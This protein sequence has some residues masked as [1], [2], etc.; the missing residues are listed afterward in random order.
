MTERVSDEY[1]L[2]S[3]NPV[4][5]A[6]SATSTAAA[7]SVASCVPSVSP[8]L[9][10]LR[11]GTASVHVRPMRKFDGA[12]LDID[13]SLTSSTER[14]DGTKVSNSLHPSLTSPATLLTSSI[15]ALAAALKE[16]GYVYIENAIPR[17]SVLKA[18]Q[19][20]V[21]HLRKRGLVKPRPEPHR[22]M[23]ANHSPT[24]QDERKQLSADTNDDDA[25][26][27][28]TDDPLL[29]STAL[30]P[31]VSPNLLNHPELAYEEPVRS[32]LEHP[33]LVKIIG[34]I[35]SEVHPEVASSHCPDT[36][37]DTD[38]RE[39]EHDTHSQQSEQK[40]ESSSSPSPN[41]IAQPCVWTSVYKWMRGV[42]RGQ[43]TS[44]HLDSVYMRST[45]SSKQDA[46][47]DPEVPA[48]AAAAM[49]APLYSLWLPF[50]DLSSDEGN[51]VVAVASHRSQQFHRL[52]SVYG[53]SDVGS[54][55]HGDGTTD[56]WIRPKEW[57]DKEIEWVSSPIRAGSVILLSLHVLH[58]S[59]M[60]LRD[61]YRL[62]CDTRWT[63]TP[64]PDMPPQATI[65]FKSLMDT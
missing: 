15:S 61:K 46:G 1:Q 48:A 39:G 60:N 57:T 28:N 40:E 38:S 32:V 13:L 47:T 12:R 22:N 31:D 8:S 29:D 23:D 49:A 42:G 16:D 18:R 2:P 37:T 55:K 43:C 65:R 56:G 17:R 51:L 6:A 36:D 19:T 20:I 54:R 58:A 33:R 5:V 4:A 64:R 59:S 41:H 34:A 53:C 45:H 62:S 14:Q 27:Y 63:I 25:D 30:D 7:E 44:F 50:G 11:V 35:L 21:E 10:M 52:R 26:G 3:D 9:P 24:H